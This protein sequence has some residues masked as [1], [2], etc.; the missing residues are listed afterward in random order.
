MRF[1]RKAVWGFVV[2]SLCIAGWTTASWAR[3]G[4]G[5]SQSEAVRAAEKEKEFGETEKKM[6]Q[7]V[8]EARGYGEKDL[9]VAAALHELGNFYIAWGKFDKVEKPLREA[10]E[11]REGAQGADHPE[12]VK[13]TEELA[14]F[15][16]WMPVRDS[17]STS[18]FE[19]PYAQIQTSPLSIP[20]QKT[21]TVTGPTVYTD[22]VVRRANY[23]KA[24]VLFRKALASREKTAGPEDGS[25]ISTLNG[26]EGALRC[27]GKGAEADGIAARN[28]AIKR[29]YP[30][31]VDPHRAE[32]LNQQGNALARA[33]KFSEAEPLFREAL[34][35]YEN[36]YSTEHVDV[37]KVAV[38][39]GLLYSKQAKY[40]EA[41]PLFQRAIRI[42]EKAE[43]EKLVL[44]FAL[45]KYA[46]LLRKTNRLSEAENF[47]ARAKALR[48]GKL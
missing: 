21:I 14:A 30:E 9:R 47:E 23:H 34:S 37:A 41:E 48:A 18:S 19:S 40:G 13:A 7:A 6:K 29:K 32:Q 42:L 16:V 36:A 4:R 11:I 2:L 44:V 15:L 8:Q 3:A 33:G 22:R 35:I 26:L 46:E 25:L 31:L 27:Q 45:E 20:K 5:E 1:R 17:T 39:L 28:L 38:S 24:E 43:T 12:V 10:L